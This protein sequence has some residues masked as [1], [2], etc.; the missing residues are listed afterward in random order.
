[1]DENAEPVRL[2]EADLEVPVR[3]GVDGPMV[4][5]ARIHPD[6]TF[7]GKIVDPG[8]ARML[9]SHLSAY[10]LGVNPRPARRG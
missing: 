9:G 4:G 10:S 3:F 6:G 2:E 1:M 5:T 7:E 8:V